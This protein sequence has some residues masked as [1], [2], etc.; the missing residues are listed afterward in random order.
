MKIKLFFISILITIFLIGGAVYF[1]VSINKETADP[2][3]QNDKL[4]SIDSKA[5]TD[6]GTKIES[7]FPLTN[8]DFV[9]KDKNN[10]IEL[11]GNYE[12]LKTDEKIIKTFLADEN[13]IY[14]VYE[15]ENF[16]LLTQPGGS[17]SSIIGSIDLTTSAIQT[18]RGISV[19]DTISEVVEK[20][21]NPDDSSIADSIAPGQYMYQYNSEFLTFFVDKTGIVVLI[22]F[23][24]V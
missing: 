17:S 19:G 8:E 23:E 21:G 13:N 15:F 12:D 24:I 4:E 1:K 20:Y 2:Q 6:D 11:G 3:V 22:R 5:N 7:V 10:Y 14:D 9:I 18:S 16:K